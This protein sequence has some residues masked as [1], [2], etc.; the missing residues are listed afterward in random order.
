MTGRTGRSKVR[1][2]MLLVGLCLAVGSNGALADTP[3]G[4]PVDWPE[5]V[6]DSELRWFFRAEQLEYRF[7][8]VDDVV[9]WDV[10]GWLGGDYNRVWFTSEGDTRTT[11]PSGGIAELQLLYGRAISPFW[12]LQ[13]GVRQ[14]LIFGAGPNR[15]RTFGVIGFTGLA[16]QWFEVVPAL[17]VSD[18]GDVSVRVEATYDLFL[19][20]RIVAQPR[21]EFDAAFSDAE[22]FGVKSGPNDLELGLRLRYEIRREIAPY[23]GVSWSRKLGNTADL[24]RD[25]GEE[26][27]ALSFV[28]GVRFWF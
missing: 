6:P 18:D 22:K 7:S 20:Q 23:L 26:V 17:F 9:Q 10:E 25:E 14:D 5:P 27:D 19:T 16:P 12:N 4:A 8:D 13:L 2:F 24:A 3:D 15:E 28:L 21:L 11:G 1:A